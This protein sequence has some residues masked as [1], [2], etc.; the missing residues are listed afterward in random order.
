MCHFVNNRMFE[1]QMQDKILNIIKKLLTTHQIN[2][3]NVTL[4]QNLRR[5]KYHK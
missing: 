2:I 5:I 3:P 1:T 4:T